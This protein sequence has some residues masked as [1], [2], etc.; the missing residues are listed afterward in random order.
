MAFYHFHLFN[1]SIKMTSQKSDLDF[2]P[3]NQ[4]VFCSN[5]E[6]MFS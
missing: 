3:T 1:Q 4:N 5:T 2:Y 6:N